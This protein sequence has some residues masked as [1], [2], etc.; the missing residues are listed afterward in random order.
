MN[1]KMFWALLLKHWTCIIWRRRWD[2]PSWMFDDNYSNS[3]PPILHPLYYIITEINHYL[4]CPQCRPWALPVPESATLTFSSSNLHQP[5]WCKH[6]MC[7]VWYS[8][9]PSPLESKHR[10][11]KPHHD[12]K[13]L[14]IVRLNPA[15]SVVIRARWASVNVFSCQLCAPGHGVYFVCISLVLVISRSVLDFNL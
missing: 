15:K 9:N 10:D 3:Y 1:E 6:W 4:S 2:W 8:L 11:L 7:Q 13:N 5:S 14:K 12:E